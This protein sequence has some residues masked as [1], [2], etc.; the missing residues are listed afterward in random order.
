[1]GGAVSSGKDNDELIDNL[2]GGNYIRSR[3]TERVFR[4]LDRADY[5][6]PESRDQA[7]KD[8]AWRHGPLHLSAP[9]IYSE[10]MEGLELKPG[11]SFLNIGS[12]TG[13]LSTMVGLVIGAGGINHGIEV[14]PMV[15]DYS[16]TKNAHFLENSPI[17]DDFD[18]CEPKFFCGN[19]L[20]LPPLQAAYDRVYVGAGCPT[21]YFNYFK[22]LIKV[23]GIL[24]MP[25]NDSLVQIRHDT[26][27]EWSTQNILNV[28]FATL[29]APTEE[30]ATD[31][32]KLDDQCPPRLQILSRSV[33]RRC[34]RLSMLSRHPDLRE[35]PYKPKSPNNCPRRICIPIE[36]DTDIEGLNALHDLDRANGA[37]EM[38]ALLSLVLSMGQNRVAGALRFDSLDSPS[39]SSDEE[40]GDN[41]D[42]AGDDGD[43]ND[44]DDND[45][46]GASLSE[47]SP[48]AGDGGASKRPCRGLLT[49][50][51]QDS[52][53][54]SADTAASAS[55]NSPGEAPP[56]R[57]GGERLLCD[58]T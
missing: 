17:L 19:G 50:E 56:R 36:D 51:L 47:E 46:G 39:D 24:V 27:E 14:H 33:I 31:F 49:F 4:A 38:N 45:G 53:Q 42:G 26:A 23:G 6:T 18:F 34:M 11:L 8:L 22:Q 25:L 5:M 43:D 35:P 40:D 15:V 21:E 2:M 37:N 9:C 48:P 58:G 44:D 41:D 29:K 1:M 7:Y 55:S 10:V 32:I 12:G 28:S 52:R 20:S 57:E 16:I 30:E 3:H 54:D 13:Y